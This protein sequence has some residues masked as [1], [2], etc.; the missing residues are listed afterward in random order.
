MV[1]APSNASSKG[2]NT[3]DQG[4]PG[5]HVQQEHKEEHVDTDNAEMPKRDSEFISGD[6]E[7]DHY[8]GY[9]KQI[10]ENHSEDNVSNQRSHGRGVIAGEEDDDEEKVLSYVRTV[11]QMSSKLESEGES[12]RVMTSSRQRRQGIHP[13][14]SDIQAHP[15]CQTFQPVDGSHNH[16]ISTVAVQSTR[17]GSDDWTRL[18]KPFVSDL[19]FRSVVSKKYQSTV[20]FRPYTCHA[21]VLLVDLCRYSRITAAIAHRGAHFLSSVV[22]AYLSRLLLIVRE[23]GGDVVKFAGDAI[24]VIWEGR[25]E[26]SLQNNVLCAARC[27]LDLQ[28]RAPSHTVLEGEPSPGQKDAYLGPLVFRIHCGI[29]CGV[30]ESEVF[31]APSH[32]HMQRLFHSVSGEPLTVMGE[33][34][35]SAKAG[36][37]CV[38]EECFAFLDGRASLKAVKDGVDGI[39]ILESLVVED[40]VEAVLEE[41]IEN[42]VA[43]RLTARTASIEEE[44]INHNVLR[45]LSHGGL[46]PTQI[47]QMRQ[48]CVLFIAMTSQGSSVNWLSEVQEILDQWRCPIVQIIDDD[49]GVHIV[50]AINLY[51]TIPEVS[52]VGVQV[53][54]DLENREVGCAIGMAMG[55]CFCGVTGSSAFACRWDITGPTPVRAARL[56]QYALMNEIHTAV[57]QSVYSNP[58]SSSYLQLLDQNVVLKGSSDTC[59]VYSLSD[60]KVYAAFRVLETVQGRC[61]DRAVAEIAE[62]ITSPRNRCA[63]MVKGPPVSGKKIACQRAAGKADMVPFLHLCDPSAGFLQLART[64][65]T[66]FSYVDEDEI[67]KLA[68]KVFNLLGARK[69]CRALDACIRLVELAVE[70]GITACFLVDRI[71]NLDNFSIS[72]IRECLYRPFK[73]RRQAKGNLQDGS[74]SHQESGMSETGSEMTTAL[75][76]DGKICFLC[77]HVSLYNGRS[78]DHIVE[79]ITRRNKR[80]QVPI[81]EVVEASDGELRNMFRDMADMEVEDRWLRAYAGPAGHCAGY[82]MSRCVALR[83][84][85]G[86]LWKEGKPGYAETTNRLILHI[87]AGYIRKNREVRVMQISADFAMRFSQLYDEL[88]PLFQMFTKVLHIASENGFFKIPRVIMWEV[89]NDLIAE[90]VADDVIAVVI[91]WMKNDYLIKMEEER[92]REVISF[93]CPALGD[94]AMDV[95]TPIQIRCIRS[96]L[97]ERLEAIVSWSFKVP[98]VL[99]RLYRSLGQQSSKQKR[100]LQ[101]AYKTFLVESTS[102][103]KVKINEWME[104]IQDEVEEGGHDLHEIL[105]SNFGFPSV[106]RKSV[107]PTLPLVKIYSAPVAFGPMANSLSV[108]TRNI[109]HECK[110]FHGADED[111]IE[112]LRTSTATASTRYLKQVAIVEDYLAQHGIVRPREFLEEEKRLLERIA[113]PATKDDE[114]VQK[115]VLVLNEYVPR[116]VKSRLERVYELL[117]KL[118]VSGTPLC[119]L[120]GPAAIKRAYDTLQSSQGNINDAAQKALMVLAIENWKPR[121]LSEYLPIRHLHTVGRVRDKV[122]TRLSEAELVVFIHQQSI[123]DLEAFLVLTPLLYAA[124]DEGKC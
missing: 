52:V 62:W 45:L 95:C 120:H 32:K 7:Y 25:D 42:L 69:W 41:H 43:D 109:F 96:A 26:D 17:R 114:V 89:L 71:Q 73:L 80:I 44:F 76:S 83:N 10:A 81:V 63:V 29:T 103:P 27:A 58:M 68:D 59:S 61:H 2:E 66:W 54:R 86:K 101:E 39:K 9:E 28:E 97:I 113:Q 104:T 77:V 123:E 115:A 3:H 13:R 90:G 16:R 36:E 56:M 91:E 57:D 74:V 37:V 87:P 18:I 31:A 20:T 24:L 108:V 51:E 5:P 22:N 105:G 92:D 79:D 65:A 67:K 35:D 72:L 107:G 14:Q 119:V 6:E 11:P 116:F 50:A 82:F 85:S 47:A 48:L 8:Y 75:E 106:F 112:N 99:A 102:W 49:K 118:R 64:I 88:P 21:A 55:L 93:Q 121:P 19:T 4:E 53:C 124:Q 40:A 94:I 98:L 12:R 117:P 46:S 78:A 122:L 30:V 34:A 38:D 1:A 60:A 111:F 15:S 100:L 84:L 33:V 110:V 70:Q 23:H